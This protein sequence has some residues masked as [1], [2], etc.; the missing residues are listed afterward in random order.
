METSRGSTMRG[1]AYA[2]QRN[3]NVG[4][5]GSRLEYTTREEGPYGP[6]TVTEVEVKQISQIQVQLV[7]PLD[8]TLEAS[9]LLTTRLE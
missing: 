1:V 2:V 9:T 3:T 7:S 6:L 4:R 5:D 8:E